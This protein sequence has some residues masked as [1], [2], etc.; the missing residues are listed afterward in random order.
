MISLLDIIQE[1]KNTSFIEWIGVVSGIGYVILVAVKS[2]FA[3]P[4]ALLSSIIYVYLCFKSDYFLETMLQLF[5]V[6][7]ALYGWYSWNRAKKNTGEKFIRKWALKYHFTNIIISTGCTILL[8]WFFDEYTSQTLPYL[9]AF[10]TVFSI[11][12]TFMV[13]KRILGNWIYWIAIDLVSVQLYAYK[14]FNLTAVLYLLY[15]L[16]AFIGYIKWYRSY[17]NQLI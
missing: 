2:I 7:M 1:I 8:G 12:A 15:T 13:T 17:Q 10:T 16:I 5:Y 6:V 4:A 11:A 9:D 3:W 14:N